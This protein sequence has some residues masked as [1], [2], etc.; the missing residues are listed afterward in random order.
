MR[1]LS[2]GIVLMTAIV[3]FAMVAQ[4]AAAGPVQQLTACLKEEPKVPLG[5]AVYSWWDDEV[6]RLEM[7]VAGATPGTYCIYIEQVK[8]DVVFTVDDTGSGA[9]KLDTRWGDTIPVVLSGYH[10]SLKN[11]ADN[12]VVLCGMFK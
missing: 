4:I 11:C 6:R 8:L 12:T 1:R 2:V 7:T 10:I 9:L 3:M 5:T